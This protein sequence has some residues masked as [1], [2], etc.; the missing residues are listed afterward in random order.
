MNNR[1]SRFKQR[2]MQVLAKIAEEDF[3]ENNIE[4]EE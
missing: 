4:N 3:D 1:K 2:R